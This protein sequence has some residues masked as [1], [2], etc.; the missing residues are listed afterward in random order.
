[1]S[2]CDADA[3]D[4]LQRSFEILLTRGH[5]VEPARLA[6]W[7]RTVTRHEALAVRRSRERLLGPPRLEHPDLGDL[8]P[9][10]LLASESPD[11]LECLLREENVVEALGEITELKPS[12]RTALVLQAQGYSYAEI[13]SLCGWTY[14]KVNRSLAEGRARLRELAQ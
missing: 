10:D 2:L 7:M 4:A 5:A 8:D 9:F 1:M 6:A 11:P 3:D 14:T 13:C 12:E